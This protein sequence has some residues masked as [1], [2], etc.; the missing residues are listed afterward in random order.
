MYKRT[1]T[2]ENLT[3]NDLSTDSS[4]LLGSPQFSLIAAHISPSDAVAELTHLVAAY[5][6]TVS[7]WN[8]TDSL[9][10]GD[11]NAGCSYVAKKAWDQIALWTDE[12]F[13]WL[14]DN[15]VDTTVAASSCPYDRFVVAGSALLSSVI[16][17]SANVFRFD[18]EY[19][20]TSDEADDV[21]DHY[22]IELDL[23][24][25]G[26][27]TQPPSV[28]AYPTVPTA[29]ATVDLEII[30]STSGGIN[31]TTRSSAAYLGSNSFALLLAVELAFFVSFKG[32]VLG[33]K[34]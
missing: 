28:I 33:W 5:N 18:S 16:N 21:S 19:N 24:L 23:R 9:L 25:V 7:Q 8:V 13:T 1:A 2:A 17:G 26:C 30:T 11:F 32:R 31:T 6:E 10:L 3:V 29:T 15:S 14:L 12:R 27:K 34:N 4:F 22:P 20:L